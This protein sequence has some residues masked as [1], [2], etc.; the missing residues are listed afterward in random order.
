[1]STT[2]VFSLPVKTPRTRLIEHL[3]SPGKGL[4]VD[5]V[6]E[7]SREMGFVGLQMAEGHAV[8]LKT[9]NI[10]RL[11]LGIEALLRRGKASGNIMQ[12]GL[13]FCAA[14]RSVS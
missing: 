5:G 3:G 7:A 8:S 12:R 9:K 14:R 1:M 10:W 2:S 13:L 6:S 11:R 4:V